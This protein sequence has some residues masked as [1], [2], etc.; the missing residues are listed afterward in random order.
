MAAMRAG[1]THWQAGQI[2]VGHGMICKAYGILMVTHGPMHPITKDLEVRTWKRSGFDWWFYLHLECRWTHRRRLSIVLLVFSDRR[3]LL[4]IKKTKNILRIYF[5]CHTVHVSTRWP[6]WGCVQNPQRGFG[7][8]FTQDRLYAGTR[9]GITPS[10]KCP[11][12]QIQI[13]EV[14]KAN[15][16][17]PTYINIKVY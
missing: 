16:N 6:N 8:K 1:V 4:S 15:F 14:E 11:A 9:G 13:S 17:I 2:E 5:S 7:Q 10:N 12:P 3:Q